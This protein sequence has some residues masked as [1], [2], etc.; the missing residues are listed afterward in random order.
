MWPDARLAAVSFL[1]QQRECLS[2]EECAP[3]DAAREL[4]QREAE[5]FRLAREARDAFQGW[6]S[7]GSW[8]DTVRERERK[9][10]IK[11]QEIESAAI[12]AIE[13][14]LAGLTP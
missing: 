5:L 7:F 3:L 14:T 9:L 2:D 6:D 4:Y 11:A 1:E 8:T 12:S 10:L 13:Q